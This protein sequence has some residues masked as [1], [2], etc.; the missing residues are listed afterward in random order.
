MKKIIVIPTLIVSVLL[1]AALASLTAFAATEYELWVNGQQVTSDSLEIA[2]GE[3]KATFDPEKSVLTLE[4]A[5]ITEGADKDW[6]YSGIITFLDDLEIVIKGECFIT[7]TGGTGIDSYHQDEEYAFI[8]H[9]VK[10]T[11]DGKLTIVQDTQYYG[12]GLY[13]TGDLTVDGPTLDITS[14]AAGIWVNRKANYNSGKIDIEVT[15]DNYCGLVLNNG[16]ITVDGAE[17]TANAKNAGLLLGN[18]KEKSYLTVNSGKLTLKGAGGIIAEPDPE[19]TENI[20][21]LGYVT[22]NGG[23]LTLEGS[24]ESTNVPADQF[25]LGQGVKVLYGE[26]GDNKCVIGL[27][28]GDVDIPFDDLEDA[29][30]GDANGDGFV[31]AADIVRLKNHLA[32]TGVTLS[33]GADANGDGTVDS[34]DVVRLKRFFAEYDYKSGTSSVKLGPNK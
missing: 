17:I 10:L 9:N 30:W 31:T 32:G 13:V 19:D 11:G 1:F 21:K 27:D 18:D 34:L 6:L 14:A 7:K 3:G 29:V 23:T 25:T 28:T 15:S 5:N 16:S 12:Y 26:I 8:P 33:P 20:R 4:N 24:V 22:V 2:C